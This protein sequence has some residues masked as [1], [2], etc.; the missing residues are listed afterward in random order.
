MRLV[1]GKVLHSGL[2][3]ATADSATTE[4]SGSAC[5]SMIA[6]ESSVPVSQSIQTGICLFVMPLPPHRI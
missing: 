1:F 6:T 3:P 2:L 5:A 4:S